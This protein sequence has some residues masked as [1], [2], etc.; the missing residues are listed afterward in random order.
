[1]CS[2]AR[3]GSSSPH[4]RPTSRAQSPPQLTKCSQAISPLSVSRIHVPSG[5]GRMAR[6]HVFWWTSAPAWRAAAAY[7]L[8][9]PVGSTWPP[10]GS[11]RAPTKCCSSMNGINALA[12]DGVI[13]SVC[14]PR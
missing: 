3:I 8:V 11:Q 13:I 12:S 10:T 9:T 1:M 5:P 2:M 4:M 14:M 7:A 6:T